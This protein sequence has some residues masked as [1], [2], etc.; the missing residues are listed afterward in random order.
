MAQRPAD[1]QWL[2]RNAARLLGGTYP[3]PSDRR[4]TYGFTLNYQQSPM[5][6]FMWRDY[7]GGALTEL[8]DESSQASQLRADL[9]SADGVVI[10]ID[11]T[12]LADRAHARAKLRPVIAAAVRVLTER[13]TVTPVVIALTK[14]DLVA[15]REDDVVAVAGEVLGDLVGAM[16]ASESVHGCLVEIACGAAPLNVEL[17]VL[18]CIHIGVLAHFYAVA[19][20]AHVSEQRAAAAAQDRGM[21]KDLGKWLNGQPTST[22]EQRFHQVEAARRR[23][24]LEPI[25]EPADRLGALFADVVTF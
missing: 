13:T 25:V 6:D 2:A 10:L 7:R 18:W 3:A 15:G 19:W 11:S 24:Y 5:L 22:Q 14:W 4:A 8:S 21:L 23:A 12:Q 16:R 17:P 9:A 1:H 20:E